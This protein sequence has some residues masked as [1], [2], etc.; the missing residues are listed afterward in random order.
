MKKLKRQTLEQLS[1]RRSG[2]YRIFNYYSTRKEEGTKEKAL[3]KDWHFNAFS[4]CFSGYVNNGIVKAG[5]TIGVKRQYLPFFIKYDKCFVASLVEES[6]STHLDHIDAYSRYFYKVMEELNSHIKIEYDSE[7]S[8]IS[9]FPEKPMYKIY[10]LA[11]LTK[12]RT[13]FELPYAL[14]NSFAEIFQEDFPDLNLEEIGF[15]LGIFLTRV[16]S[17]HGFYIGLSGR[18]ASTYVSFADIMEIAS[19]GSHDALNGGCRRIIPTTLLKGV[20]FDVLKYPEDV[21]KRYELLL[22]NKEVIINDFIKK[23][24]HEESVLS[25]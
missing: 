15:L 24:T 8:L 25:V 17:N 1:Q 4:A 19:K 9:I 21:T 22:Q 7:H 6:I 13:L 11:Y 18:T 2:P 20:D 16:G 12:L 3:E 10:M 5:A 23:I 14:T